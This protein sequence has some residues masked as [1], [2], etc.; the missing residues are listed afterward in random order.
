MA[1]VTGLVFLTL[2]VSAPITS[3]TL[4]PFTCTSVSCTAH[5]T[6]PQNG[7]S[8]DTQRR[9][10]VKITR[11]AHGHTNRNAAIRRA[12]ETFSEEPTE[13]VDGIHVYDLSYTGKIIGL[14]DPVPGRVYIISM[15]AAQAMLALGIKR[16]DVVSPN[17]VPAIGGAPSVTLHL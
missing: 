17:Y 14:P 5:A 6:Q 10:T 7:E 15:I 13:T 4:P 1:G 3:G 2:V 12:E 16:N 8:Y 11:D 9:A